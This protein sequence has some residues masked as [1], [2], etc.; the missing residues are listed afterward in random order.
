MNKQPDITDATRRRI[1][2]A[3]WI[4]FRN[5]SPEKIT[6]STLAAEANLHRSSF[7]RYFSDVY[8]VLEVF[9]AEL[10][11]HLKDEIDTIQTSTDITLPE[12]TEKISVLLTGS[13]DKIYRLL[14]YK[15]CDFKEQFVDSL[16]PKIEKYL[17]SDIKNPNTEYV[18]AFITSAILFNF[19]FW[20]EHREHYDL[21]QVTALG[22]NIV[23]NGLSANK[24]NRP[25]VTSD[26]MA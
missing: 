18:T 10:L 25:T 8:Q 16:K 21:Q 4:L 5:E 6:V 24:F 12:Y 19:N 17:H 20:Y 9:Q 23:L 7:Y 13:A 2:D 26:K 11:R 14:N 3:F 22:K 1:L 15:G